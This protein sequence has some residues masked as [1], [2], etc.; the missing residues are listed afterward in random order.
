MIL[1]SMP[2]IATQW[3]LERLIKP[4]RRMEK[5]LKLHAPKHPNRREQIALPPQPHGTTF[6]LGVKLCITVPASFLTS[7]SCKKHI[8]IHHLSGLRLLVGRRVLRQ[9]KRYA[10]AHRLP[11]LERIRKVHTAIRIVH[12]LV[13]IIAMH[14][15]ATTLPSRQSERRVRRRNETNGNACASLGEREPTAPD[16]PDL[17]F[18][19]D[20]LGA[21]RSERRIPEDRVHGQ[22]GQQAR[23]SAFGVRATLPAADLL[24]GD[25][26][27][28]VGLGLEEGELRV[29]DRC[30][31][32][33][34]EVLRLPEWV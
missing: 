20:G 25:H 2:V 15:Q 8:N 32:V 26:I 22:A 21:V 17:D 33:R 3:Q 5:D 7:I 6:A 13:P 28:E 9:S 31:D 11:G 14:T 10:N 16:G 27:A 4:L 1:E 34:G 23:V 29:L 12:V 18:K 19:V 30:V 24:L